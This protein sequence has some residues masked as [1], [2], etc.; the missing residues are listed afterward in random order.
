[1]SINEGQTI[2]YVINTTNTADGT[3]LYW[4]ASG[5]VVNSQ[6]TGG[7]TGTVVV[8]NNQ[9]ILNVALALNH[10]TDG[11]RNIGISLSTTP[12]GPI[13]GGSSSLV[14]INDTSQ[15]PAPYN[16]NYLV[17]A[18]GGGGGTSLGG[19][20]GGAGGAG[21]LLQGTVTVPGASQGSVFTITVG[22]GGN[23]GGPRVCSIG[24]GFIG[25]NSS[26][27]NPNPSFT[28]VT[29]TG[30]G[31]GGLGFGNLTYIHQG[32]TGGP[33]GSGGGGGTG[34]YATPGVS[35]SSYPG[36]TGSPGQGYP[37]GTSTPLIGAGGG[38]AGGAGANAPSTTGGLGYT[39]PYTANT[40]AGGGYGNGA[41]NCNA[42]TNGGG[43][44]GY[45]NGLAYTGGGGGGGQ[46]GGTGGSGIVIFAVPVAAPSTYTGGTV[47]CAP[48]SYPGIKLVT[49]TTSGTYTS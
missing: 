35:Q 9:A 26:F 42:P 21:G 7:N 41:P 25:N 40:Y 46:Y 22:S 20:G 30:G 39:W 29:A 1:M 28:T 49:F 34:N 13:V 36:G 5:N 19:P 27:S 8:T 45:G 24:P 14:T 23:G 11:P 2:Q 6:I 16:I 31:Y 15:T 10:N 18:G 4:T 33:G 12:N 43:G 44:G 47:T 32:G 3:V 38:G 48:P 37:G 17:V